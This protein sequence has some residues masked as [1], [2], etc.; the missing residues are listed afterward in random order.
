M[1]TRQVDEERDAADDGAA[2]D[3]LSRTALSLSGHALPAP[4]AVAH[5]LAHF[6]QLH[7]LDVSHMQGSDEAPEGLV[8]LHWLARAVAL[9]RKRARAEGGTSLA[10]RLTWLNLSGTAALGVQDDATDGLEL[11]TALHGACR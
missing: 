3:I 4:K 10:Q 5:T 9:S 1:K 2:P 7:R 11:L 8:N 6:T